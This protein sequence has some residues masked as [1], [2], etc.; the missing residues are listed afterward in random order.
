MKRKH[1]RY[2]LTFLAVAL[3][4]SALL[5]AKNRKGEQLLK[6]GAAAQLQGDWDKALDLYRQ[7]VD[8]AP[9]D[10]A[11]VIAM[12]RAA[13][14][15]GQRHVETG[16]KL[17]SDGKVAEAL[18]EFQKAILA[19]PSSAIAL[20][21]LKRTQPM[22]DP[23]K[24]GSVK[25]EDA[26]LTAGER[27]RREED[28][29]ILSMQGP[30]VLEPTIRQLPVIKINNQPPTLVYK[31]VAT[32]AGLRVV[33][34]SQYIPP[35]R[36]FDVD[37]PPGAVEQDLD[38]LAI[39]THTTWKALSAN[40]I[41]VYEDNV[42]KR[43]DYDD[44]VTQVFYCTNVT[45]VQEFQ[46][47]A[48]AVRTLGEVRRAIAIN[49]SRAILVRDTVDKVA[50]V[51][52]LI[53]DL[54]K[55]K[56]EVVVDVF[57]MESN[58]SRTRDLGLAIAN[59]GASGLP[60]SF[61][62]RSGI[63]VGATTT[64]NP[65]GTTTTT[66]GS[67]ALSLR[68]LGH[69]STADFSTTVPGALLTAMIN[70]NRTKVLN[71]PQVRVS[72]GMKVELQIGD[73]IPYASGS[74]QPGVGTVGVNPLVQTQFQF[75]DTGVTV[76]IQPQVHSTD[77]VTLH[78]DLNVSAVKQY[79]NLGGVSQ[80]VIGQR[81][82]STDIRLHDGEV[83]LLGGLSQTQDSTSLT[84]IPGLGDIPL[85][86]Y[87]FGS[88]TKEN[89]KSDLLIFLVPHIVRTPDF[90]AENLRGIYVGN[91][92]YVKINYAPAAE[93]APAAPA[94]APTAS[95]T[96]APVVPAAPAAAPVTMPV[97]PGN[98]ARLSFQPGAVQ[99]PQTAPFTLTVH[100]DGL[101]DAA[102]VTP[103]QIKYDP[104]QLRLNDAVA[105]D[106]LSR[107]GVRVNVAKDIRNDT[108]DATITLTRESGGVSGSGGLVTLSFT[109]LGRGSGTVAITGASLKNSQSQPLP[110]MLS[111]VPVTIQ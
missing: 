60:V 83:N 46:E 71:S 49:A 80:P 10:S 27:A 52:K 101:A 98:P 61:T 34:D 56:A 18:Q 20:Q 3:L 96:P 54:D 110:A 8:T 9:N 99:V 103:L 82:T 106:L 81:K 50:L 41:F 7:A 21:E 63:T 22:L 108:G 55:P 68:N 12:R 67:S 48:N 39:L 70:D 29:K 74:F 33:F 107:D 43:H 11:Y 66:G 93:A 90:T 87:L 44:L 91:E 15:A 30:P 84:G 86:K 59:I 45:S 2:L 36:G 4:S 16:Q 64:T 47:I 26:G 79:L 31:S 38:Y 42:T 100:A 97:P 53:H 28:K 25:P 111:S 77:E 19:D 102:S 75:A 73:R 104:A 24:Q 89:D 35:T 1:L 95:S 72:D 78:V 51:G 17:R 76:T 65:D 6:Q 85:L 23:N 88:N 40:T 58:N 37:L 57:I 13:F 92:T 69:I 105:G 109:A 5:V 32:L 14:E 62:P 94:A